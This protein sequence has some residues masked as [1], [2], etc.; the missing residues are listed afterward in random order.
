M[1]QPRLGF[2][3]DVKGDGK[4]VAPGQRGPLL[5]P[6]PGPQPGEQPEHRRLA[7][8]D[9]VPRTARSRRSW[10]RRPRYGELLPAPT[11]GPFQPGVFVFDK[12]FENPR[13]F[14]ATVGYEREVATGL[15]ASLSYTHART[16]HLTR[17]INGNDAVFGSSVGHGPRPGGPTG[18]GTLTVVQSTAKSR[19]N[20]VTAELRQIGEPPAPVPGQLHALVRQVGRRQRG[21]RRPGDHRAR[22]GKHRAACPCA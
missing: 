8:A 1:F 7:R 12:D 19:F 10:A 21:R 11:G 14:T 9:A 6:H 17:F 4:Q 3:Y 18:S 16:D 22:G 20:G 15:A 2:A 5:R 13:T